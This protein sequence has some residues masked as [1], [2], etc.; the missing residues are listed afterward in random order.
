MN[1]P[2]HR[3]IR[4]CLL[5]LFAA[6]AGALSPH[7]LVGAPLGSSFTYQGHLKDMGAP[8]NG[9]FDFRC[10]LYDAVDFGALVSA[11]VTNAAVPVTNGLFVLNLDFGPSVFTGQERWLL[12]TIRPTNGMNFSSLFPR[13]RVAPGP[14]ALYA[15]RAGDLQGGASPTFTGTVSFAPA[16]GP[17]FTVN[18]TTKV[19]N[20]NADLL[21]GLDSTAFVRKTGDIM[22]GTLEANGPGRSAR[23]NDVGSLFGNDIAV[24][25]SASSGL[26]IGVSASSSGTAGYGVLATASGTN[27]TAV[28]ASSSEGPNARGL[29]ASSA[30]GYAGV[31]NGAVQVTYASPFSKPHLEL[32]DPSDFGFSR[33][34][35]KTGGRSFWDIAVGTG[36]GNTNTLRF[37]NEGSG[38]VMVLHTNGTLL[39]NVLT[40]R[41]GADLAEPFEMPEHIAKG[42]V[43]IIDD[44]NPGRLKLSDRAYDTRVAGIVSGANGIQPG[45]TLSQQGQLERGQHVALSGRVYVQAD[46]TSAP[47]KPGD[48]LTT[49]ATPGCA[50]KV[51]EPA[52]AQGAIL[53]KAMSALA[54]GRGPVLVLV[55]LQ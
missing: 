38:D 13:Q 30:S 6:L 39:C 36:P 50:M 29:Y 10:Q 23:L 43:V 2:L 25:G 20:L 28:Y 54:V 3:S 17:P 16:A 1:T 45:L 31:F 26:G 52:R 42:A 14:Y 7:P 49:A 33:L 9:F 53:G 37:F 4:P 15:A 55:T 40:I 5:F 51:T 47:I 48:L 35:M 24:A 19:P 21:D 18:S 46:A 12:I 34:R 32:D 8:A 44:E 11:T 27:G 22:T 41:G